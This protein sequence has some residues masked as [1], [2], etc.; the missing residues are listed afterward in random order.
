MDS[1]MNNSD[2]EAV[3]LAICRRHSSH[4]RRYFKRYSL[5]LT[6]GDE[7]QV[8]L[9]GMPLLATASIT[10]TTSGSVQ[11][12]VFNNEFCSDNGVKEHYGS[13]YATDYYTDKLKND[14]DA[15]LASWDQ[16]DP[17]MMMIGF[18]PACMHVCPWLIRSRT[19]CPHVPN[20]FAPQY[21]NNY[22]GVKAPRTPNWNVAPATATGP[23]AKHWFLQNIGPSTL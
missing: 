17:F 2:H 8:G 14:S 3:R 22:S 6:A 7:R 21:A 23:K 10:T 11:G 19:P 1:E 9:I 16:K 18:V 15:F 12:F 20:I 4:P 5:H 13:N